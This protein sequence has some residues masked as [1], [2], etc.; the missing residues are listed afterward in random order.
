MKNLLAFVSFMFLQ[1]C[2]II[3]HNYKKPKDKNLINKETKTTKRFLRSGEIFDLKNGK[4]ELFFDEDIK[5]EGYL[6]Y[7]DSISTSNDSVKS[8]RVK[9][10]VIKDSINKK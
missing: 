6:M 3:N 1:S 4:S 2:I 8:K 7:I 10:I 9:V 5:P